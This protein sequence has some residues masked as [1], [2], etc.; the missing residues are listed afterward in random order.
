V[1]QRE[2]IKVLATQA[3][4]Q[5]PDAGRSADGTDAAGRRLR[6]RHA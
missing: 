5:P 3:L 4:S 1:L 6:P 2:V